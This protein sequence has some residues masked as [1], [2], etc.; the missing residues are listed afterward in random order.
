[1]SFIVCG[2]WLLQ[3]VSHTLTMENERLGEM[4]I[5]VTLELSVG[6]ENMPSPAAQYIR[7]RQPWTSVLLDTLKEKLPPLLLRTSSQRGSMW[8]RI[9]KSIQRLITISGRTLARAMHCSRALKPNTRR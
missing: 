3:S 6:L 5:P 2:S 1:M 7:F 9:M 4:V 8:E